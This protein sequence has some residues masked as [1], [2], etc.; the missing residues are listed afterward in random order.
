[1]AASTGRTLRLIAQSVCRSKCTCIEVS[2]QITYYVPLSIHPFKL[3]SH[4]ITT[5]KSTNVFQQ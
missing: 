1:M 5:V 2:H 3:V 4:Q